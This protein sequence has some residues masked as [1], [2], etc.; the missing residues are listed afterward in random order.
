M[1]SSTPSRRTFLHRSLAAGAGGTLLAAHRAQASSP[2]ET[3]ALGVIGLGGRGNALA[4]GF[5]ERGDSQLAYVCDADTKLADQ[6]A[7]EYGEL[8]PNQARP[9]A[10][11]DFRRVLDDASVDAVVIATPDHWHTPL[12]IRAM[13]AGKDVYVEKPATV[14]AWE[15][16]QLIAAVNKSS[17]VLQVGTQSRSAA[18]CRAA[19]QYIS[20]GKLGDIHVCRVFNMKPGYGLSFS[21]SGPTPSHMDWDMWSGPAPLRPYD[22]AIRYQ[23]WHQLWDYSGGDL[24]NDAI[25]QIDLARWL[26]GVDVPKSVTSTGGRFEYDD[27]GQTPDTQTSVFRFDKLVMTVQLTLYTPYMLKTD[28]VVRNSD[29]HP[30]WSQNATRIEIYGTRGMMVV[31]RH[32]G[33][34]QVFHRPHNR[35]PVV[36]ASHY[37]RFPDPEH[38][39]NFIECIR[40]RNQPNATA[41]DGHLSS[42]L[43]H[44]ANISYRL[45]GE[46][47]EIAPDQSIT[48]CPDAAPLLKPDYRKPWTIEV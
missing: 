9:R 31:G 1:A 32:G 42:L 27:D 46:K 21:P 24:A 37:G 13:Q 36:A 2:S 44:Y 34:W 35:Q 29:R 12:A 28:P 7:H 18:Y 38:K 43:V 30:L 26:L 25:H 6:R 5:V 40:T 10:V 17:R 23:G 33:G 20:S 48:D 22:K 16:Q 8:A 11:Q 39:Q 3:V 47:L 19:K 15:G 41:E 4:R 45:D 14:N